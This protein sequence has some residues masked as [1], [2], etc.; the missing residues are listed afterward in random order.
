M[1]VDEFT[2]DDVM[3][4][5]TFPPEA[6][7]ILNMPARWTLVDLNKRLG[8]EFQHESLRQ[9]EEARMMRAVYCFQLRRHV[10]GGADSSPSSPPPLSCTG[11]VLS[12]S[13]LTTPKRGPCL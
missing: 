9:M 6:H 8:N 4:M 13:L 5:V 3:A 12:V 7:Q 10:W 1:S 11:L 2:D